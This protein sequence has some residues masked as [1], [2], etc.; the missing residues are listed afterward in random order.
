MEVSLRDLRRLAKQLRG[1]SAAVAR[2]APIAQKSQD[3]LR[4]DL[5]DSNM[6]ARLG[7]TLSALDVCVA[8]IADLIN[9]LGDTVQAHA[10][11]LEQV[12]QDARR[13][14]NRLQQNVHNG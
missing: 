6:V 3:A 4:A 14:I 13:E 8:D 1:V 11:Q 7:R 9:Q 12:D 10:D 2:L 5:E